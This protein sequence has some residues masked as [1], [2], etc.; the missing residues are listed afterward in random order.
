MRPIVLTLIALVTA[1]CACVVPQTQ[2]TD[3]LEQLGNGNYY[4][5]TR[6]EE[7][8]PHVAW[9]G[10]QRCMPVDVY[11]NDGLDTFGRDDCTHP[12]II[13]HEPVPVPK[14]VRLGQTGD[15]WMLAPVL[16]DIDDPKTHNYWHVNEDAACVSETGLHLLGAPG[17]F[18]NTTL[19]GGIHESGD[20]IPPDAFAPVP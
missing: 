3:R 12:I 5:H 15:A 10:V 20:V 14:Y 19:D 11:P 4:D 6:N 1:L 16:P 13:L 8:T 7:C 18:F 9:D 2:Q 17:P